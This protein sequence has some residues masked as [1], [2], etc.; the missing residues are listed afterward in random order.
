[1]GTGTLLNEVQTLKKFTEF[2]TTREVL[3]WVPHWSPSYLT[4]TPWNCCFLTSILISSPHLSKSFIEWSNGILY[5]FKHISCARY[6]VCCAQLI[7][8]YSIM[9]IVDHKLPHRTVAV[10][11]QAFIIGI[12][13][14]HIRY[15]PF[16]SKQRLL[17]HATAL[18]F[19]T[20][21]ASCRLSIVL[22]MYLPLW[23]R[24]NVFI[25]FW[26]YS[27]IFFSLQMSHGKEGVALFS[28]VRC[29]I[30]SFIV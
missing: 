23:D 1:M 15:T 22:F 16:P 18:F 12:S 2:Y 19:L 7:F 13:H 20:L 14:W 28:D 10:T 9:A 21:Q 27:K 8:R 4:L 25:A 17:N 30:K 24:I 11:L 29:I 26:K 3:I 5:N 6:N